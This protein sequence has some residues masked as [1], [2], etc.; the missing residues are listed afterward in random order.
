MRREC[1]DCQYPQDKEWTDK[2]GDPVQWTTA[3]MLVTAVHGTVNRS[4]AAPGDKLTLTPEQIDGKKCTGWTADYTDYSG[5]TPVTK[6]VSVTV[7]QNSDGTWSCTVPTF[8]AM[9]VNG[10]GQLGFDARF[11]ACTHSSGTRI[12]GAR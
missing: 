8:A 3:N 5:E 10:G 2:N 6:T 1:L 7:T 12:E 4:M 9:G 11:A